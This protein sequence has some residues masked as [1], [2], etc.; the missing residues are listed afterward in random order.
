MIGIPTVALLC[1]SPEPI[2]SRQEND[3]LAEDEKKQNNHEHS[4][5]CNNWG[6]VLQRGGFLCFFPAVTKQK[7]SG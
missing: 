6:G 4:L 2:P 1:K 7:A 3:M 5:T